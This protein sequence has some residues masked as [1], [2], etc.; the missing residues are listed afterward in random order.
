MPKSSCWSQWRHSCTLQGRLRCLPR[1]P[2]PAQ[3][4]THGAFGVLPA[5]FGSSLKQWNSPP[6]QQHLQAAPCQRASIQYFWTYLTESRPHLFSSKSKWGDLPLRRRL[7][8]LSPALQNKSASM[9][10]LCQETLSGLSQP[11]GQA[12]LKAWLG[13]TAQVHCAQPGSHLEPGHMVS[14]KQQC[15]SWLTYLEVRLA[16]GS[17]PCPVGCSSLR[18]ALV[19]LLPTLLLLA[20][21]PEKL[22]VSS[23]T[24][25]DGPSPATAHWFETPHRAIKARKK[26]FY[27]KGKKCEALFLQ[28]PTERNTRWVPGLAQLTKSH[29]VTPASFMQHPGKEGTPNSSFSLCSWRHGHAPAPEFSLL[30]QTPHQFQ[31]GW[32]KITNLISR[33][34]L[35]ALDSSHC[36]LNMSYSSSGRNQDLMLHRNQ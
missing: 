15:L 3:C 21:V 35:I 16:R 13:Q 6:R 1:L 33:E 31:A 24:K 18:Y 2:I 10:C 20:E 30:L 36:V 14:R 23:E 25:A 29:V 7:A 12:K 9:S 27:R 19:H 32:A 22:Q 4:L 8:F 34:W 26:P 5:L 11:A 28:M 17:D